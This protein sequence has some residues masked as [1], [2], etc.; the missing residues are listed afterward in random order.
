MLGRFDGRGFRQAAGLLA[1]AIAGVS[2]PGQA[3]PV[4]GNIV[5]M[6]NGRAITIQ[7]L[8]AEVAD[9]KAPPGTDKKML[10]N[11]ALQQIIN[12]ELIVQEA[13]KL[14]EHNEPAFQVQQQRV[15]QQLLLSYHT[16]KTLEGI[17]EPDAKTI[18]AFVA[19]NPYMFAKRTIYKLDQLQFDIPANGALLKPLQDARSITA[20]MDVLKAGN[21]AFQRSAGALDTGKVPTAI[22]EKILALP[23]GEPFILPSQVA[24]KG[25]LSII[26][27]SEPAPVKDSDVRP[28]AIQS[29][30]A[31]RLNVLL[32]EQMKSARA[33]AKIS[34]QPDYQPQQ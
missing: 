23:S 13:R 28:L 17:A 14:G 22:I 16:R 25:I 24:G 12:R 3:A 1:L 19:A 34:Y 11:Y 30:R 32:E 15:I 4:A 5:A 7:E 20:A 31:Q 26:T 21:I 18:D 8:A 2:T 27:G 29:Y 6:V 9:L 10:R 33:K